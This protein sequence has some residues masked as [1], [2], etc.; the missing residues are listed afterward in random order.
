M[1]FDHDI[2]RRRSLRLRD[3]DYA[4]SGAYFVTICTHCRECL[5]GDVVD[6]Q[7]RLSDAGWVV[8]DEWVKTAE[9]RDEIELDAWVVMPNHFHAIIVLSDAGRGDRPCRGD[10]PVAPT[11]DEWAVRA[12]RESPQKRPV[13]PTTGPKPQSV[14]AVMAGFKSAVTKRINGLRNTP[15]VPVWQRNYYDHIIRNE[16]ALT[17]IREYIVNN[18]LQWALDRENPANAKVTGALHAQKSREGM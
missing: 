9:I 4:Q 18:P 3:Y 16:E 15:S 17:R 7:M 10:R 14:G 5:F 12:T 2:R 8:D 13:A 11:S 1:T 6:G